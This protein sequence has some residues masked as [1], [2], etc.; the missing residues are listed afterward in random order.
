MRPPRCETGEANVSMRAPAFWPRA[1]EDT[2][3]PERVHRTQS[4]AR[5]PGVGC[6]SNTRRS[7]R[8]HHKY[9]FSPSGTD[10]KVSETISPPDGRVWETS[11]G[12][13]VRT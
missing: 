9:A 3:K 13:L 11:R 10:G 12:G 7:Q 6:D 4:L 1:K 5:K 8:A 2:H